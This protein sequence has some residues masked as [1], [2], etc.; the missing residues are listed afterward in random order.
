MGI[1]AGGNRWSPTLA[2]TSAAYQHFGLTLQFIDH[3][4][5]SDE[6]TDN[7]GAD[8]KSFRLT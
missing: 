1:G 8:T 6:K 2:I 5:C 7:D 3:S 4:A